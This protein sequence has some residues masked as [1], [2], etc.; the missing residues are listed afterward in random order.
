MTVSMIAY[1]MVLG[2][3]PDVAIWSSAPQWAVIT[4]FLTIPVGT[5]AGNAVIG[6]LTDI[7]GRKPSFMVTLAL[8][9]LGS[10]VALLSLRFGWPLYVLLASLA[11]TQ[12]GL[13]GEMPAVLAYLAEVFRGW[14]R[15]AA[16]ILITDVANLGVLI[17]G[18]AMM[19]YQSSV[20]P[21]SS[22][23]YALALA[24]IAIVA[25]IFVTRFM[26][27]ES[28]EWESV[29]ATER[30]D[31]EAR[32]EAWARLQGGRA[33]LARNSYS[34]DLRLPGANNRAL[35]VPQQDRPPACDL[36]RW[37][38]HRGPHRAGPA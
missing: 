22:A 35:P 16:L 29:P 1:G 27:P 24:L 2:L 15:A 36:Q 13:G 5:L 31:H 32:R 4:M 23:V 28:P 30:G 20:I 33:N 18:L 7:I 14:R 9:G 12:V 19:F 25:V 3:I 6:R 10:F 17:D 26:L 21:V 37:R 38:A 34:P 11:V 8:Y